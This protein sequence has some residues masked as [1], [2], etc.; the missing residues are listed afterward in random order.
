MECRLLIDEVIEWRC[1]LLRR[2]S[3]ALAYRR[4]LR[5]QTMLLAVDIATVRAVSMS[6][7]SSPSRSGSIVPPVRELK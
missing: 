2:M 4:I 7:R 3:P 5:P 6:G 1:R